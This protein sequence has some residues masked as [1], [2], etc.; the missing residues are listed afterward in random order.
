MELKR[1]LKRERL[2]K[3]KLMKENTVLMHNFQIQ[4]EVINKFLEKE[5]KWDDFK[6]KCYNLQN[7]IDFTGLERGI[8]RSSAGNGSLKASSKKLSATKVKAII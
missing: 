6:T 8:P 3:F 2:L 5:K 1:I 4:S 7:Q